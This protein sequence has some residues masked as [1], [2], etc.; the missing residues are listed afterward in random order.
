MYFQYFI[1]YFYIKINPSYECLT[2]KNHI[3]S[4]EIYN[5]IISS[6]NKESNDFPFSFVNLG[7]HLYKVEWKIFQLSIAWHICEFFLLWILI[8]IIK[9]PIK[10][11]KNIYIYIEEFLSMQVEAIFFILYFDGTKRLVIFLREFQFTA[12]I[13]DNSSLLSNQDTNWFLVK[14]EIEFHISY[15]TIRLSTN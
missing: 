9:P 10:K 3:F 1:L 13:S 12:S 15:L 5:T 6:Q 14:V 2:H 11:K 7:F 4:R 8:R